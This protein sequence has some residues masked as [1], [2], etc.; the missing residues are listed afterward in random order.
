M[1]FHDIRGQNTKRSHNVSRGS[2]KLTN[3]R[4]FVPRPATEH[5]PSPRRQINNP[6]KLSGT[7]YIPNPQYKSWRLN[8]FNH[9][10]KLLVRHADHHCRDVQS[11]ELR[12]TTDSRTDSF[13]HSFKQ[14]HFIL[15]SS[16][17]IPTAWVACEVVD[18]RGSSAARQVPSSSPTWCW[19]RRRATGASRA[20]PL[21]RRRRS[22]CL[23]HRVARPPRART[24]QFR[25]RPPR[26]GTPRTAHCN[27]FGEICER[28]VA[29]AIR[30]T[31]ESLRLHGL[32]QMRIRFTAV[33]DAASTAGQIIASR[34]WNLF[35]NILR[36][37]RSVKQ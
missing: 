16:S 36:R 32:Q 23:V 9:A 14:F 28:C 11:R 1:P 7:N 33:T 12:Q 35:R 30:P 6:L 31:N 17:A 19:G 5:S 18:G 25:R 24:T 4:L 27:A 22:R 34:R 15:P 26:R 2:R 21:L 20:R 13:G 3:Y 10:I 29:R 37:V 8:T